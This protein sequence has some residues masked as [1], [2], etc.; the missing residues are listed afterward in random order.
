MGIQ[1]RTRQSPHFI[2]SHT[3]DWRNN[4]WED[5]EALNRVSEGGKGQQLEWGKRRE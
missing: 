3:Y 1:G 2:S 4:E 5:K